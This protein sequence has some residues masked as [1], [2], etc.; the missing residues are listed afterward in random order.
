MLWP[1]RTETAVNKISPQSLHCSV[2]P[3]AVLLWIFQPYHNI[4]IFEL[5][6]QTTLEKD[7]ILNICNSKQNLCA[8]E[9][10]AAEELLNAPW[11]EISFSAA[12]TEL[13]TWFGMWK[14]TEKK[15]EKGQIILMLHSLL[16]IRI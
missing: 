7:G 8:D 3:V 13:W 2:H 12:Q 16:V 1:K 4:S 5:W 6:V 14:K 10:I 11:S 15:Q 9:V